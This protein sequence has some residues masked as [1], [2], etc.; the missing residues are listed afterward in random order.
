MDLWDTTKVAA[1]EAAGPAVA[2]GI[3]AKQDTLW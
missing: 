1:L 2:L 3:V